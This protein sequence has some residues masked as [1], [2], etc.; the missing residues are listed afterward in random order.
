VGRVLLVYRLAVRDLRRHAGQAVLLVMV[1]AATTTALTLALVL[2]GV[3]NNPWN[4]TFAATDGA[5][6]VAQII[7]AQ[8]NGP[9]PKQAGLPASAAGLKPL[10]ALT[11]AAGVTGSSGPYPT[12]YSNLRAGGAAIS[13]LAEGRGT[14]NTGVDRPYLT[15]GT[16]VRPGWVVLDRNVADVLG[17]GPG[18]AVTLGG[19]TFHVAGTAVTVSQ[20]QTW[21][22][23]LVWVTRPDALSFA[24][25]TNP[26]G[27]TLNLRL[28]DPAAA[29]AFGQAHSTA[30][31]YLTPW[32]MVQRS[33][34]K[35]ISV[36]QV[37]MLV[38]TWLLGLLAVASVAVLVGGR[39][40]D[41][42]RRVGL[43]KA[44]GATPRLVAVVLLAEHLALALAA[45]VLGLAVGWLAAPL[46]AS[47]GD[48]LLGASGA[49]SLTVSTVLIAVAVAV[50]VAVLATVVPAIR[51]ARAST[52][53]SL[54]DPARPPRR[55]PW[56]IALSAR[57]PVPLLL[58]LRLA[59]RR[60]R[61]SVLA[62][63]SLIITV[64]MIV[65]A[66]TMRY[67]FDVRATV[68]GVPDMLN[69]PLQN[70]VSQVVALLTVILGV[71]AAIN[72]IF[73]T[74]ATVLDAQ[75]ASALARA[76]GT[77]PRQVTAGLSVAQLLPALAGVIL[78]IPAGLG[79]Y[80]LA[81]QAATHGHVEVMAP[82]VWWL[83]IVLL[84]TL[85]AVAAL[86]AIPAQIG[87][88]RPVAL[89]LRTE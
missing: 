5:D 66:L 88:R 18:D 35:L 55:R 48:A 81:A 84:G 74:Q 12:V 23:G 27:Y 26:V 17:V 75:R 31:M 69:V 38:G 15:A 56:L 24:S 65:A 87:A 71:L 16:W 58:G 85:L 36:V 39:M 40:A 1:I 64:A 45:T 62:T 68:S 63:V 83:L 77:T 51:A 67:G 72:T 54:N 4:R 89:V 13:V 11:H 57:L 10:M 30:N 8:G 25:H 43:L 73:I 52:I 41:Q 60:P 19:R 28:A 3:T 46:L 34:D 14:A 78:G 80:R 76:F 53:R 50:G 2:H 6:V 9:A 61:R 86:T 29:V 37:V 59:S 49:P 42:T 22:P 7:P 47:P 20:G 21:V 33:D 70:R 44:V 79:L 82:P 32:Q